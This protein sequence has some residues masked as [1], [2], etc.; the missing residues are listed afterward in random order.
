MKILY[1]IIEYIIFKNNFT[2]ICL[3][4]HFV[5]LNMRWCS[6][7]TTEENK[8]GLNIKVVSTS[9]LYVSESL[10][11]S[12]PVGC[13]PNKRKCKLYSIIWKVKHSSSGA[14][15]LTSGHKASRDMTCCATDITSAS[16][17][18]REHWIP[19][20]PLH[21]FPISIIY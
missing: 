10:I 8:I 3:N 5:H 17:G 9:N 12:I 13:N 1:T 16:R 14:A 7:F 6:K 20:H 18:D 15:M 2:F 11:W 21:H 4:H 19:K